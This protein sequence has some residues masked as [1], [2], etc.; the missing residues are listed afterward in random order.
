[1]IGLDR[2]RNNR[3]RCDRVIRIGLEMTRLEI[4]ALEINGLEMIVNQYISLNYSFYFYK[5][6]IKFPYEN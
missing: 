5:I 1:M 4:I 3:V 2:D 6:Y